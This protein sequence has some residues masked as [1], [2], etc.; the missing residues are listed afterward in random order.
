MVDELHEVHPY[1]SS[2]FLDMYDFT[3]D[4]C[5]AFDICLE[6]LR[7]REEDTVTIREIMDWA[8]VFREFLTND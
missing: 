8:D 2:L 5:Q 6:S 4:A 1:L 7:D 3:K